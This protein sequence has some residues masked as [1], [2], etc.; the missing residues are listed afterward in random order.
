[1]ELPA[2]TRVLGARLLQDGGSELSSSAA[3]AQD[4]GKPEQGAGT[5]VRLLLLTSTQLIC[6]VIKGP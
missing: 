1:M 5:A 2:G 4:G 3:A 6:Y